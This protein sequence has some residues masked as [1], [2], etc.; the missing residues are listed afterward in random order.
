[1]H[2]PPHAAHRPTRSRHC[3]TLTRSP[4]ARTVTPHPTRHANLVRPTH[5]PPH[6]PRQ[7]D[8]GRV[9]RSHL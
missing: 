5:A 2:H 9:R 3:H 4:R 8:R 7:C 6:A 1:M